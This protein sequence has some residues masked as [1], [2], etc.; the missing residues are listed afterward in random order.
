MVLKSLETQIGKLTNDLA[1]EQ[2]CLQGNLETNQRG[3]PE[4][5]FDEMILWGDQRV[6]EHVMSYDNGTEKGEGEKEPNYLLPLFQESCDSKIGEL[7][8]H[9]QELF[10]GYSPMNDCCI[11]REREKKAADEGINCLGTELYERK[12][13]RGMLKAM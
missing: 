11:E 13:S 6:E 12:E 10:M 8:L 7:T 1:N 4:E 3:I 5:P 9:E 2:S